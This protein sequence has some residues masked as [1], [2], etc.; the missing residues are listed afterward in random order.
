MQNK[1][2][3]KQIDGTAPV[4]CRNPA[5]GQIIHTTEKVFGSIYI[6]KGFERVDANNAD[7]PGTR[8]PAPAKSPRE[9]ASVIGRSAADIAKGLGI[10]KGSETTT[11]GMTFPEAAAK[12]K[13]ARV[14]GEGSPAIDAGSGDAAGHEDEDNEDAINANSADITDERGSAKRD[15]SRA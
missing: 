15:R 12:A 4:I 3:R 2:E 1:K 13:A 9:P 10:D 7:M 6:D 8:A 5:S 11:G 14:A